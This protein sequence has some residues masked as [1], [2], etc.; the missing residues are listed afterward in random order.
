[1]EMVVSSWEWTIDVLREVDVRPLLDLINI[2]GPISNGPIRWSS[3]L[4]IF[5]PV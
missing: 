4:T 1:M 2:N 3:G 5:L